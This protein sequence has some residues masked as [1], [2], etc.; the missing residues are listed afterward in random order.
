MTPL[1]KEIENY[2]DKYGDIPEETNSRFKYLLDTLKIKTSELNTIKRLIP[3]LRNAKWHRLDFVIY[4]VPKATPRPRYSMK[5][6]KFYVFDAMNNSNMIKK[7]LKSLEE[8]IGIICT[9]MK[10]DIVGY[11]P[12]PS[13]MTRIEKILA[14]LGLLQPLSTPDFD[15]MVKTYADAFQKHL[16]LN[17]SLIVDSHIKKRYSCKP[18]VEITMKFMDK[19]DCNYNKRKVQGWKYYKELDEKRDIEV[20]E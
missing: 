3:K 6:K 13:N 16:I 12:T 7:F 18:R 14:E 10:F 9:P 15:N 1:Q 8:P 5:T 19:Y 17:D 20:I 2:Q 11:L 4:L